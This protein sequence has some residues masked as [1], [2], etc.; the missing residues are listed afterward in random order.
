LRVLHFSTNEIEGG[1]ARAANRLHQGLTE[2]GIDSQMLVQSRSTNSNDVHAA[3]SRIS[4]GLDALRPTLDQIPLYMQSSRCLNNIYTAWFPDRLPSELSR[5]N[6]DILHLHW[7]GKG[8]M[9]V[10]TLRQMRQPVVWTLHDMW[11]L[12]GGCSHSWDCEKFKEKCGACPQLSS[13]RETDLSRWIWKRKLQAWTMKPDILICPSLWMF[14]NAK[15]SS[16]FSGRD[17]RHIPHGLN[18]NRYQPL[19]HDSARHLLGLPPK[20]PLVIFNAVNPSRNPYKG[21][22]H[23]PNILEAFRTSNPESQLELVM[24]GDVSVSECAKLPLRVHRLG[25]LRDDISLALVYAAADMLLIPSEADNLPLVLMESLACGTPAVG[26]A[27]GGI[28]EMITHQENG[29][30]SQPRDTADM[31]RGMAWILQDRE[32][33]FKLSSQARSKAVSEYDLNRLSEQIIAVYDELFNVKES[34]PHA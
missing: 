9:R 34:K 26:F 11:P 21:F 19:D 7:V 23:L 15:S 33:W 2:A 4:R 24:I 6:P 17:I 5:L 30:L 25:A 14:N 28:P 22:N 12:T 18:L 1:A 20:V 3:S 10:E 16:L 8:A 27:V 31:A 13:Q 29:W 32:R